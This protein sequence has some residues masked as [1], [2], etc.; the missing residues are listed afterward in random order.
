VKTQAVAD[1]KLKEMLLIGL[2]IFSV[3]LIIFELSSELSSTSIR[4]IHYIDLAISAIFLTDFLVGY[5]KAPSKKEYFKS[6]WYLLLAAIPLTEATIRSLRSARLLRLVRLVRVLSR[7][8][9]V[10]DIASNRII[11]GEQAIYLGVFTSLVMFSGA[12]AFFSAELDLNPEVDNFFD[13]VWWSAVTSTTV[14]YG[15]ISPVTTEGRVIAM[16][17]MFYGVGFAGSVAGLVGSQLLNRYE[18]TR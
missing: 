5:I 4:M 7:L 14:G 12:V 11:G 10:R 1:H 16:F 15:D 18:A 13:A 3:F 17:L 8:K 2:A 9:R 6:E